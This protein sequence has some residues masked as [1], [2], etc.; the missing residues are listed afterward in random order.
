MMEPDLAISIVFSAAS[1]GFIYML[2]SLFRF[3]NRGYHREIY[4]FD[5]NEMKSHQWTDFVGNHHDN[6]GSDFGDCSDS[7]GDGGCDS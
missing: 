1:L 5:N 3:S 4:R 2:I 6:I 7:G